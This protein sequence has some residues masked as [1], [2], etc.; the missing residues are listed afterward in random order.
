ML[1]NTYVSINN[2]NSTECN[3]SNFISCKP[4]SPTPLYKQNFLGE[5]KTDLEKK[6]VLVNLG[7]DSFLTWKYI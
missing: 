5:F 3:K 4:C 2:I 6:K 7:L 1:T